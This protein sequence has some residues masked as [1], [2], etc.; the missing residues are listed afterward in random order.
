M[1]RVP[2]YLGL[3]YSHRQAEKARNALVKGLIEMSEGRFYQ[4]EKILLK[5]VEH[6]DTA[7]LN[8]LIAARSPNNRAPM[9]A[10]MSTCV[11]H[12]NQHLLPILPLALPRRN[13][14]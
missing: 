12:M 7:L 14:R 9:N 5:Q 8:Y 2:S 13:C 6:S 10:V 1:L 11:W 4:A 3:R